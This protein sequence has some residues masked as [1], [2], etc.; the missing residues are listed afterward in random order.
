LSFP[1]CEI[2][3]LVDD[4][5]ITVRNGEFVAEAITDATRS[6]LADGAALILEGWYNA[7]RRPTMVSLPNTETL[8][9]FAD[10]MAARVS[11]VAAPV[12]SV[13]AE[14]GRAERRAAFAACVASEAI[15]LQI[16]VVSEGV[17]LPIRRLYD[18]APCLSPVKWLQQLGRITR[19]VRPGEDAPEYFCTNRNLLRHAYLLEGCLPAEVLAAGVKA[20]GGVGK[21]A[22]LRAVGLEAL[23]RLK[24]I[25]LPLRTG[26]RDCATPSLGSRTT[27]SCNTP[28][29][30]IP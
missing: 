5:T 20:F 14:T 15:L 13:T 25:E 30:C 3:P 21:Y 9:L 29:S 28:A 7:P 18:F 1:R 19:P 27:G 4:E 16:N 6:R 2:V 23:G 8:R 10:A 22:A 12:A 24:A 11:P 17:D 26:P